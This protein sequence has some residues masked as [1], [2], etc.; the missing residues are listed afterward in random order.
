MKSLFL[1][2]VV[3]V[4][5]FYQGA[6]AATFQM[7]GA[8]GT[9][10]STQQIR[11][12][13][14]D[15]GG[16]DTSHLCGI[17]NCDFAKGPQTVSKVFGATFDKGLGMTIST[18]KGSSSIDV[19]SAFQD[20]LAA[21]F[22]GTRATEYC[23]A[24]ADSIC[25]I[26]SGD[27]LLESIN[28]FDQIVRRSVQRTQS[29]SVPVILLI[30]SADMPSL[31]TDDQKAQMTME[32]RKIVKDMALDGKDEKDGESVAANVHTI[33]VNGNDPISLEEAKGKM[34]SLTAEKSGTPSE[35]ALAD[36]LAT[37][38]A[39]VPAG[40]S[41]QIYTPVSV[42]VDNA[43]AEYFLL[44]TEYCPTQEVIWK[45]LKPFMYSGAKDVP[46]FY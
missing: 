10:K 19:Y 35:L 34:K 3:A 15:N 32:L 36:R 31:A 23:C 22:C 6:L 18:S 39:K 4:A 45:Y 13:L 25:I 21:S 9:M 14:A 27:D 46:L 44:C 20:I 8:D 42:Y 1:C 2:L 40:A 26:L 29:T 16:D 38:W 41:L 43:F 30:D 11:T 12:F 17:L 5:L 28:S 7:I 33:Y 24:T 37:E